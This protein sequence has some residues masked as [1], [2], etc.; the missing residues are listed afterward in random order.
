MKRHLFIGLLVTIVSGCDKGVAPP[1]NAVNSGTEAPNLQRLIEEKL[2]L[3]EAKHAAQ[4]IPGNESRRIGEWTTLDYQDAIAQ[5]NGKPVS[6]QADLVDVYRR[7][8]GYTA[9]FFPVVPE[10]DAPISLEVDGS[11][12]R[13]FAEIQKKDQITYFAI[14]ATINELRVRYRRGHTVIGE[15]GDSP[16]EMEVDESGIDVDRYACG[17]LVEF[18]FVE[19]SFGNRPSVA[20]GNA[21][22]L[23]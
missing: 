1:K 8:E 22:P 6:F 18:D 19:W 9:V 16:D 13:R 23:E 4:P 20:I 15:E 5:S 11:T 17:R 2:R 3:L 12:A 21:S 14:I 7:K 10:F